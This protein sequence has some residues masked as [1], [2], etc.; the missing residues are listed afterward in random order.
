MNAFLR[1]LRE[2]QDREHEKAP[3]VRSEVARNKAHRL[4]LIRASA[5]RHADLFA[6]VAE[7]NRLR[8]LEE[9]PDAGQS[10]DDGPVRVDPVTKFIRHTEHGQDEFGER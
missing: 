9:A 7:R 5:E 4:R 2:Q 6:E 3:A 8:R 10:G 1:T